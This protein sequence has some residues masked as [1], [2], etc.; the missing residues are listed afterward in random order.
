MLRGA[1][2]ILVALVAI[3]VYFLDGKY[4]SAAEAV[5]RSFIHFAIP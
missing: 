2:V 3:D 4:L 1:A 5:A